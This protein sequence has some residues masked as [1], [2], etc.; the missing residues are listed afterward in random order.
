MGRLAVRA[1]TDATVLMAAIARLIGED[2]VG[3][4]VIATNAVRAMAAPD[5]FDDVYWMWVEDAA[6]TPVAAAMHTPP[7]PPHLVAK[8]VEAGLALAEH[9]ASRAV[10]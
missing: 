6:K 3:T 5:G 4:S 9:L 7:W 8:D 2:P 1:T 10:R